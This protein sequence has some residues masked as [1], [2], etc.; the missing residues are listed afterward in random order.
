MAALFILTQLYAGYFHQERA[1]LAGKHFSQASLLADAGDYALA[2][3]QYRDALSYDRANLE[4]QL[5]F[6]EALYDS[7][8]YQEAGFR[9]GQLRASD[10]TNAVVNRLLALLAQRFGRANEAI[11]HYRTA[12]YG[13]WPADPEQNR[14]RTRFELIELLEADGR[15]GAVIG[16]LATLLEE[17][18]PDDSLRKLIGFRLLEAKADEAAERLF[19]ELTQTIPKDA[20]VWEGLGRARLD[21]GDY[22]SALPAFERSLAIEDDEEVGRLRALCRGARDLDPNAPRLGLRRRLERSQALLKRTFAYLDYCVN[23][24]GEAFVGPPAPG[25]YFELFEAARDQLGQ[26]LPRRDQEQALEANLEMVHG[27][28]DYR[29]SL[30]TN[31]WNEDPALL[32]LLGETAR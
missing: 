22:R 1:R 26:R 28:W 11:G 19:E 14:I 9:L 3:E 25:S 6:A 16:E 20:G 7:G 5:G 31:V 23:P 29:N 15:N 12:V 17:E 4:Y 32:L 27:L 2:I 8:G 10:P 30:C 21:R 18:R 13:R 24:F